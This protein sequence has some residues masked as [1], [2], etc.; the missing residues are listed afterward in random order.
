MGMPAAVQRNQ[1]L[2]DRRRNGYLVLCLCAAAVHLALALTVPLQR[3]PR[4]VLGVVLSLFLVAAILSRRVSVAQIDRLML[5]TADFGAFIITA[6]TALPAGQL[7]ARESLIFVI[8]FV[9]WFGI[10]PLRAAV[11]RTALMYAVVLGIGFTRPAPDTVTMTYIGFLA[12]LTGLMTFT[13][14]QIREEV[15]E[16]SHFENLAMTDMVTNLENRRAMY[17][18][19][20]EVYAAHTQAEFSVLLMDIDYFKQVNDRFGHDIG[21]EVLREVGQVLS[22]CLEPEDA[23]SR[24]GGEEFLMLVRKTTPA[25]LRQLCERL[26]NCLQNSASGLPKVSLSI[27]VALG[28]EA[29]DVNALLRMADQRMYKAKMLGRKRAYFG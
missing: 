2:D 5:W 13:G 14:R 12:L 9:V 28:H 23:V 7:G 10:L 19:L 26:N 4:P 17:K 8:F 11:I 22:G 20:Q 16:T 21:D 1:Q 15:S 29:A 18:R 25:D 6:F 24:W 27:G 3:D